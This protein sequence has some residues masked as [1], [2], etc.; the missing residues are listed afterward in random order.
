MD[1]FFAMVTAIA[2]AYVA[3]ATLENT[4][5]SRMTQEQAEA[6]LG[7]EVTAET[8]VVQFWQELTGRAISLADTT[9]ITSSAAVSGPDLAPAALSS[10]EFWRPKPK[11][12]PTPKPPVPPPPPAPTPAKSADGTLAGGTLGSGV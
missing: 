2:N 4:K 12:A 3:G 8:N 7:I 10:L 5:I 1:A 11:P 9:R 6:Y